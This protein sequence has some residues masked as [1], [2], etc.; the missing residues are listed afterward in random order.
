M[1]LRADSVATSSLV[2]ECDEVA[3]FLKQVQ[4]RLNSSQ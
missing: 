2:E 3:T 1:S 4:D